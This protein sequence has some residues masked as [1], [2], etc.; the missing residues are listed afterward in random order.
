MKWENAECTGNENQW[1]DSIKVKDV[2]ECWQKCEDQDGC[3][4]ILFWT[5]NEQKGNCDLYRSCEKAEFTD[6]FE[7]QGVK[8][9]A[10]I[11]EQ[12]M[13]DAL[14]SLHPLTQ[15][16]A[17]NC[18]YEQSS[19]YYKQIAI[20]SNCQPKKSKLMATKSSKN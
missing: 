6:S 18:K 20:N 11:T 19:K 17:Q 16:N 15:I 1:I 9:F 2:D 8:T 13:Q 3:T 10:K 4:I 12:T 7:K 5:G 14:M